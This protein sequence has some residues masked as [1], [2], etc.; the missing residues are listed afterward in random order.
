MFRDRKTKREF[1]YLNVQMDE[2][3]TT[4]RGKS[5]ELVMQRIAEMTVEGNKSV[6]LTGG[7]HIPQTDQAY[8]LFTKDDVLKDC[9]T[10]A[11]YLF[12]ENGTDN[13]ADYHLYTDQRSDHIFVTAQTTVNAYA[14]LTDGYWTGNTRHTLST[15]YPLFARI[16]L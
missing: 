3:G 6:I 11:A 1:Y 8:R 12:A 16:V 7:F 2:A 13:Q 15:H 14:V 5:A 9:Y 4:A 10:S